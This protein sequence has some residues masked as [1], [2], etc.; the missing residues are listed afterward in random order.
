[1]EPE[2]LRRGKEFHQR[3]QLDWKNTA[4]GQIHLE[5]KIVRGLN[6]QNTTHIRRGRIDLFVDEIGDFVTV[7]EIKST[8]WDKIKST[9]RRKLLS[10]HQ[11][12]VWGYV[13]KYV[14]D[15]RVSVCPGIIYPSA[16]K[17]VHLKQEIENYFSE[18]CLQIVWY[19]DP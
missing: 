14:D 18:H 1:M 16:P 19:E 15:D 10:S 3:V 9:N 11:R 5:H 17:S 12:Q 13:E 6:D 8:D 7:V 4:E 2:I